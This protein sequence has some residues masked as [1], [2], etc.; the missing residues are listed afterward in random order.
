LKSL[1]LRFLSSAML[2][3]DLGP[4]SLRIFL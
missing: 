2:M 3:I 1:Y 4:P